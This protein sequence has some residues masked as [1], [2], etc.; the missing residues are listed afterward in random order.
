ML[1]HFRNDALNKRYF[2]RDKNSKS[3]SDLGSCFALLDKKRSTFFISC[4]SEKLIAA[5][6]FK[7]KWD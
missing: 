7:S 1:L 5:V 2:V 6:H 4:R 3:V